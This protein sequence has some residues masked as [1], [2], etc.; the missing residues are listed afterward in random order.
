[1]MG[2]SQA[3]DAVTIDMRDIRYVKISE[4]KKFATIG[5]G[6]NMTQLQEELDKEKLATTVGNVGHVGYTGV[7]SRELR[8]RSSTELT[9]YSVG[10][11][12]WLRVF[13]QSFWTR[14]G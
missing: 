5:A 6:I 13:Q 7:C 2:R 4:D 9:C 11:I 3:Q 8:M 12:R 1:M 10:D 14:C